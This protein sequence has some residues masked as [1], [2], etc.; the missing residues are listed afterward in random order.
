MSMI[1]GQCD[2]LREFARMMDGLM[3]QRAALVRD[4]ADIILSLRDRLQE[5]HADN[6]KLRELVRDLLPCYLWSDCYEGTCG[7]A[8]TER[9]PH[10]ARL[11][12]RAK[13]LGVEVPS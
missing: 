6:A 4:A 3:P 13:E 7:A 12:Q 9:C 8:D 1:S 11:D 2:E 10:P 5:A